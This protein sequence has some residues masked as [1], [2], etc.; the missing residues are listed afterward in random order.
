MLSEDFPFDVIIANEH[1]CSLAAEHV[2]T[3]EEE[4]LLGFANDYEDSVWREKLFIKKIMD[5]LPLCALTAEERAKCQ[6]NRFTST[7]RAVNNLRSCENNTRDSSGEMGEILLYGIMQYYFHAAESVPK[8]FYK[9]N[10]NNLVTGA[11]SIHIVVEG[12]DFSFWLGE[13][14]FYE[15]IKQ[16]MSRAVSSVKD[17]LDKEK[18]SKEKSYISGLHELRS[19]PSLSKYL[20][21]IENMLS[22]YSSVDNFRKKLHVPILLVCEDEEVKKAQELNEELRQKL[23]SNYI[24][25]ALEF[26]EKLKLSLAEAM[27]LC[28]GVKFHLILFPVHDIKKLNTEFADIKNFFSRYA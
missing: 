10:R 11:D 9:Q 12:N 15:D 27:Q 1:L 2:Q 28:K 20:P 8:I 7:T 24:Q 3:M 17:M 5:Y 14:K 23:R 25:S 22:G 21:E 26:F 13:A 6:Q 19:C 16:A 4:R 18:L